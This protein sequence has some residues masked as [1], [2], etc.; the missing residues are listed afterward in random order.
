VHWSVNRT[1]E[2]FLEK[3][4]PGNPK[5]SILEVG[6]MNINGELRALK[7]SNME[8]FGLDLDVGPG[9]DRVIELGKSF[10]LDGRRFDL[11]VASSVFEHDIQFWNTFLEI[12]RATNNTG[13]VLLIVP[14][15]G[16][17]HRHPLD[18]F[19][20]YP[21]AGI[22][23]SKWAEFSGHPIKLI[24]SF[25]TKPENDMWADFVAIFTPNLN[26]SQSNYLG[27]SLNGENWIIENELIPNTFQEQPYDLRRIRELEEENI[28]L[29]RLLLASKR[30][31]GEVLKANAR[32]VARP[33]RR[34]LTKRPL[35]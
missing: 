23:L 16:A 25:T 18:A 2:V 26:Y 4:F 24:E 33:L 19:R 9:V 3:Y 28:E 5:I 7:T 27:G 31:L 17:Y 12:I 32:N 14:S 10:P 11:V 21:D 22:A 13:I 20:F 8:W 6:S 34:W 29:R 1:F 35:K 15:Q 30:G